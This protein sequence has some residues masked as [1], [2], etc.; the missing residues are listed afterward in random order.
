MRANKLEY[1][2]EDLKNPTRVPLQVKYTGFVLIM[3]NVPAVPFHQARRAERVGTM[4]NRIPAYIK[5]ES[6]LHS[7]TMI[8]I[9]F[10]GAPVSP[11]IE[12]PVHLFRTPC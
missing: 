1:M 9:T 10:S 12:N 7:F 2:T 3:G 6:G 4:K 5:D 8:N 11:L